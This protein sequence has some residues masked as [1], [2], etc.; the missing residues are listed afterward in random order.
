M[1]QRK[2]K[3]GIVR[4][5]QALFAANGVAHAVFLSLFG[6]RLFFAGPLTKVVA[7]P[8]AIFALV[9]LAADI[10]GWSLVKYGGKT[11]VRKFGLWGVAASTA[12]AAALL[13]VS[14]LTG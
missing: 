4:A 14:S 6:W 2:P 7:L 8:C 11:R 13:I 3:G 12:I 9:G 5:A 1:F 10:V